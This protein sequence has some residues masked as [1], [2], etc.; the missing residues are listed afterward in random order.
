MMNPTFRIC[1]RISV[2]A[3]LY[4]LRQCNKQKVE[5]EEKLE[6]VEHDDWD[7]RGDRVLLVSG[8]V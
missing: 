7:N 4:K 2:G 5:V 1:C 8:F 6:L 3:H